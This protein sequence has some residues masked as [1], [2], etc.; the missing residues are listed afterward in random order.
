MTNIKNKPT[1]FL[2]V[3]FIEISIFGCNYSDEHIKLSGDYF[4]REEGKH[5]KDI[6]S[7]RPNNRSIFAEIIAYDYDSDFI[8]A[9]QYPNYEEYKTQIAFELRRDVNKYPTNSNEER[10]QSEI[11]ADS[12]LKNDSYYRSIFNRKVNY[13]IISHERNQLYG[14]LS[15]K[16]FSIKR[17]ELEV[18][19]NLKLK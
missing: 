3:L 7:S 19:E 11:I 15:K 9:I 4:Y 16:E 17:I 2:L 8:I 1:I 18:P 13:W 5:A 6:I 14:P 12:I 10:L